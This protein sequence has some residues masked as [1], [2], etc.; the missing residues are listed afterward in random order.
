[1]LLNKDGETLVYMFVIECHNDD[2]GVAC[3]NG[4]GMKYNLDDA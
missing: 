1:M 4:A 2:K 3:V